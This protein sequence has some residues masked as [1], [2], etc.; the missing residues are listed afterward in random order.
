MSQPVPPETLTAIRTLFFERLAEIN[1]DLTQSLADLAARIDERNHN[2][3]L[4]Q[5]L[6]VETRIEAMR[7]IL[8]VFRECL[9]GQPP[10]ALMSPN[11]KP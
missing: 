5:L 10:T 1:R 7:T 2:A 4:G 11:P 9:E 8:I 3:G 6:Y